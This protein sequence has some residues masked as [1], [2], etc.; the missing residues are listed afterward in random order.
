MRRD[1]GKFHV[2]LVEG[3]VAQRLAIGDILALCNLW[4][5]V[6]EK[7]SQAIDFLEFH[8]SKC[9][10]DHYSN[11]PGS[12]SVPH[13]QTP[14]S[15]NTSPFA[16]RLSQEGSVGV[17]SNPN[18]G[19]NVKPRRS[20]LPAGGLLGNDNAENRSSGNVP[21]DADSRQ[22]ATAIS[23]AVERGRRADGRAFAAICS[24]PR[25]PQQFAAQ[26]LYPKKERWQGAASSNRGGN[27]QPQQSGRILPGMNGG[28][29]TGSGRLLR[30]PLDDVHLVLCDLSFSNERVGQPLCKLTMGGFSRR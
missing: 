16:T 15:P 25:A 1:G 28:R 5:T 26:S 17:S 23:L 27:E 10:G 4:C 2:L 9:H 11:H 6:F 30:A 29:Q 19:K 24:P 7:P 3:S 12:A 21:G 13:T 22:L 14:S 20:S 18:N 8:W